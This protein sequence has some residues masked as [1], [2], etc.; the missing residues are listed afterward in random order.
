MPP[1]F[2]LTPSNASILTTFPQISV[3]M[4]AGTNEPECGS[5]TTT[6][7]DPTY[8][9]MVTISTGTLLAG[10]AYNAPVGV[11][12]IGIAYKRD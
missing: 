9:S 12:D 8:A 3:T 5:Y 7:V 4:D 1:S 2:V 6:L 11:F 10:A